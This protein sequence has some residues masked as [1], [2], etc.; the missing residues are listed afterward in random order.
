MQKKMVGILASV[1][2]AHAVLAIA[3]M[4]G[5]GCRQPVILSPHTYNNGPQVEG[6]GSAAPGAG[7]QGSPTEMPVIDNGGA[8]IAPPPE[9]VKPAPVAPVAPVEPVA[10]VA[11]G[12]RTYVVKKGDILSRI[13][14]K[15][16]VSTRALAACNNLTGKA[17]LEVD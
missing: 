8:P 10:P 17:G 9:T 3:L 5:G 13:A 2:A 1:A 14:Y 16:G 4:T 15:H 11:G 12:S 6:A 7:Q